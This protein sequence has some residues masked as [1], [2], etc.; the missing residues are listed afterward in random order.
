MQSRLSSFQTGT[1]YIDFKV[2][3]KSNS[4]IAGIRDARSRPGNTALR[5]ASAGMHGSKGQ[6]AHRSNCSKFHWILRVNLVC[7]RCE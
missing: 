4:A 6:A 2:D 5:S 1:S 3:E 7:L